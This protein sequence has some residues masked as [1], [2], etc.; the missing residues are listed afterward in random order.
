[1]IPK[2]DVGINDGRK[3]K[4][5]AKMN[6][7]IMSNIRSRL[8]FIVFYSVKKAMVMVVRWTGWFQE[9]A[10]AQRLPGARSVQKR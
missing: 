9:S 1:M 10:E 3:L 5:N 6:L 8:D 2:I 7:K 4:F